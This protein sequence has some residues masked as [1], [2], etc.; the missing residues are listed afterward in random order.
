VASVQENIDKLTQ[1]WVG[2]GRAAPLLGLMESAEIFDFGQRCGI[3]KQEMLEVMRVLVENGER[4]ALA[5][6]WSRVPRA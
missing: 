3:G 1:A 6:D 2:E 5:A 4:A